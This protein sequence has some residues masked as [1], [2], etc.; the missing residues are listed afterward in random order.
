MKSPFILATCVASFTHL[1]FAA[2]T[3]DAGLMRMPAVSEKQISFVYAGDIWVAPKEGGTAIRLSSPRGEESWPRFSPDGREIAFSG[4]YEGNEDIYVMPVSGGEPRRV[5]FHGSG[6]RVVGWWPDGKSL[7]FGSK[8]ESFT[9]RVGQFFKI[10]A[11]GGP[12]ERLPIPYG[13]FGAVSPDGKTF[14]YTMTDTDRAS[15]KRYRGGLAP[16][17]WLFNL[18][19]GTAENVTDHPACDSQPMWAQDGKLYFLSDRDTKKRANIWQYDPAK[20]ALRQVTHFTD[21]DVRYPSVGPKEIVF[22]NGGQLLLMDL[23]TEQTRSVKV[24]VV[25]DKAT[26]RPRLENVSSRVAH[27]SL[28]PTGK[29]VLF[30]ARGDIYSSPAENGITRNLTETTGIAE[31]YPAWSPDGKSIA[32]FSDRSGE[33]ELTLLPADGKGKEEQLT[34]LGPGWRYSPVWSPDSKKLVFIDSAMRIWLHDLTT[35]Q[36]SLVDQQKWMYHGELERFGVSWSSDSRW[37]AYAGDTDAQLQAIVLY[38]AKEGKKHQ[39]TS[40]YY[41]DDL[42]VFDPTGN[43]LYYRSKRIFQPHYSDFD[44]TWAYVNSH[45]LICVPLRKDL[46]SP[47]APKNDEEPVK[48]DEAK[49]DEKKEDAPKS[50][51]P[52]KKPEDSK[53]GQGAAQ[54]AGKWQGTVTGTPRGPQQFTLTLQL[55]DD[56]TVTGSFTMADQSG[57]VT[58]KFDAQKNELVLNGKVGDGADLTFRGTVNGETF[59]GTSQVQGFDLAVTATREAAI[60][61]VEPKLAETKPE[62][63]KAEDK[64]PGEGPK[65]KEIKI[66]LDG[67]ESRAVVLPV[68]SGS[69]DQIAALPGKVIFRWPPRKGSNNNTSPLSMWDIEAR[70]EKSV[71]DNVGGYEISA[72]GKK[73]LVSR[74]GQWSITSAGENA[75]IGKPVSVSL[76]VTVDPVAEWRQMFDDAWRIER[77]FFY[78]PYLHMVPWQQMRERYGNML[79]GCVTRADVNYVLGELLGELNTS[80]AYRSGGDIDG[81]PVRN[82]G[83]L[84][85]DLRLD[86]GVYR[87]ARILEVAPWD[88]GVRSPLREPGISVKEGEYLLAVNGRK[89]DPAQ[90]PYAAFQGLAEKAVIITVNDKP[91]MDGS[92]EVLVKTIGT[93]SSLRHYS[94]IEANRRRVDQATGGRCGYVYVKNTGV[95]GQTELYRQWRAQTHKDAIVIDERWN[96][97]GQIPDRFIELLKR[98]ATNYWGVRDGTNWSTPFVPSPNVKV[99]LA[100]RWSGSGGDCFPWLFQQNKLGPVIGTRTWGGLI[101]MTGCPSL[102]DGGTVTVPTFSI[103]DQSGKWIIEGH[104]V[105]PDI[106][107]VDDPAQLAKGIDPQLERAIVEIKAGLEKNPP[108]RPARPAY[109]DRTR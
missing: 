65:V 2:D 28:S 31:R 70:S 67:F 72:D 87:I 27:A 37:F 53:K 9:E 26:L 99:M 81:G 82:V 11:Q 69:I 17:V 58:G 75:G 109:N 24:E 46:P 45:S 18:E 64:K 33:Y 12:A 14:A 10:N 55:G 36:T 96:A 79:K 49:K 76:E 35:K 83:Y 100:N 56:G 21:F 94:W 47:L 40:A 80:H 15:W 41:D 3:I 7:V 38:D 85:C 106:P 71:V 43:Y 22:E 77:D 103:Y 1:T 6:D 74:S 95:D 63:K 54:L 44:N 97:G 25:T 101:G 4:N 20:K 5:T 50:T 57:T 42:P 102:V 88:T 104:G 19:T 60:K 92:R 73:M 89:L 8:R 68:G 105:D 98:P 61:P 52:T 39:V 107:I 108:N 34:H 90:E 62:E 91:T 16:D 32:Y 48:R 30:E 29:R 66:D 23:A 86:K 13:E 51:D 84:G 59:S 78:D 93:E